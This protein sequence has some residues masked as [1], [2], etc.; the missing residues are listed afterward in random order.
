MGEGEVI[1]LYDNTYYLG[2]L[3]QLFLQEEATTV[4]AYGGSAPADWTLAPTDVAGVCSS[5]VLTWLERQNIVLDF[6]HQATLWQ[7]ARAFEDLASPGDTAQ[8]IVQASATRPTR[9]C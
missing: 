2:Q 8:E 3:F 6:G 1:M 4:P 7:I 9:R 5:R